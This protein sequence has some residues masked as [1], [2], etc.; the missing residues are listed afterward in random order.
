M[1]CCAVAYPS[2]T[3]HGV[4]CDM[5]DACRAQIAVPLLQVEESLEALRSRQ[6]ALRKQQEDLQ[7]RIAAERRAPKP[8]AGWQDATFAWDAQV[9]QTLTATFGLDRFRWVA[10][11][12]ARPL[13]SSTAQQWAF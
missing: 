1:P 5:S 8:S 3:V 11:V 12:C 10:A 7:R 13:L 9:Q 4:V 6:L 2:R